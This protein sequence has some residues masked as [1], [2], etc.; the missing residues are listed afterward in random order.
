M[1]RAQQLNRWHFFN[2]AAQ[3]TFDVL[4]CYLCGSLVPLYYFLMSS[5]C[6]GSLHPVAGHFIAEHYV[7]SGIEQE[8]WSYYGI[9][10]WLTYN[11]GYHNE[12][13]D[14]PSVPWTRLPELRKLAPEFYDVLPYH[15]SWTM[16]IINFIFS[17]HSGLHGRVKRAPK[18]KKLERDPG[19]E[20]K[21]NNT[22]WEVSD[23][24]RS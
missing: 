3:L 13:H 15:T 22:G 1:I 8:T 11:V 20:D 16:V 9:L 14:F 17:H 10:N 21:P 6:A 5:F 18:F 2:I 7:F 4:I 24:V 12:H 23:A 19:L